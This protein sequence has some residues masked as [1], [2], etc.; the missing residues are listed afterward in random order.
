[1]FWSPWPRRSTFGSTP[2]AVFSWNFRLVSVGFKRPKGHQI[3]FPGFL[4]MRHADSSS[5]PKKFLG[6]LVSLEDCRSDRGFCWNTPCFACKSSSASCRQ[7]LWFAIAAPIAHACTLKSR[8]R[9]LQKD[10]THNSRDFAALKM[11][12][13]SIQAPILG[14]RFE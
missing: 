2:H 4:S 3:H 14:V 7:P 9:G 8:G 13:P 12:E 1:M 5:S 11:M 6:G 10:T